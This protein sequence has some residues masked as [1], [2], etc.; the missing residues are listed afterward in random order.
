MN[1]SKV[2]F[3]GSRCIVVASFLQ[4]ST[5]RMPSNSFTSGVGTYFYMEDQMRQTG[6]NFHFTNYMQNVAVC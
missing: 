6:I 3:F 1:R 2:A 4:T 5:C